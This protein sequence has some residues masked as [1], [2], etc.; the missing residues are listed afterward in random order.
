MNMRLRIIAGGAILALVVV[1]IILL[2]N[3]RKGNATPDGRRT[4]AAIVQVEP[5]RRDTVID[6]RQYTGDVV[7]IQQAAIFSKVSGNL[8]RVYVDMGTR[9]ARNQMLALIDTTELSQQFQQAS[10]TYVNALATARRSEE[11]FGQNLVAKQDRDNADAAMKV[12]RAAF[13][14]AQTHLAYARITAPFAGY[15]TKRFLDPGALVNPNSTTLFTLMDLDAMKVIINVLEQDIPKVARGKKALVTVDAYPGRTFTGTVTRY[16]EAV[17]LST[18]TMAV[19]IDIPNPSQD[20]KP[21]MFANVTL[22]LDQHPNALTVPTQAV[23]KD[24]SGYFLFVNRDN[25]ARRIAIVPGIEQASRTE[26]LKG[27]EGGESVIVVGQ[28]FL[29]DG[30]AISVQQ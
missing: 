19:E 25:Y 14:Q 22:M 17:D 26:V 18:R 6:R 3:T 21:G 27:L 15:V 8:E 9:V 30:A 1:A 13:E 28:A 7:A 10:A 4:V 16:A 20:L 24:D 11:L 23:L 2:L 29:R 12:A 5:P